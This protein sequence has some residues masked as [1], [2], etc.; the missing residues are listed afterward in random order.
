M[1]YFNPDLV[2]LISIHLKWLISRVTIYFFILIG[3][4]FYLQYC[5]ISSFEIFYKY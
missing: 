3:V 1:N 5:K 4:I 2:Q